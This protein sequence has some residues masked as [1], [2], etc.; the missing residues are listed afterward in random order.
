MRKHAVIAENFQ[1]MGGSIVWDFLFHRNLHDHEVIDLV[2]LLS[3]LEG[4]YLSAGRRDERI[5]K[6]NAKGQFSVRA[7]YNA[8]LSDDVK[9][10]ILAFLQVFS[11][12]VSLQKI[13]TLD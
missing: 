4:V 5:W 9:F 1:T 7:F 3:L 11:W 2:R 13:R 6:P 12:V 8:L 10:G